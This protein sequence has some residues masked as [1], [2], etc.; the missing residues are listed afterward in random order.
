MHSALKH[1]G[2]RLYELA[3]RGESVERPPRRILI[4]RIRRTRPI[5]VAA[6]LVEFEVHCSKGTYIRSLAADIARS[7]GT[8]GYV[9]GLRRLSVD[10]FAGLAMVSLP[11]LEIGRRCGS[12]ALDSLLLGA[13]AAFLDLARVD[14][15]GAGEAA[16][17]QGQT[18]R[19]LEPAPP[20]PLRAYA[21][22]R[23]LGL[24]EGQSDGRIHPTRLFVGVSPPAGPG[25]VGP[26]PSTG[27]A[28]G[29][30]VLG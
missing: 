28:G 20:G 4:E 1:A 21:G 10:P 25:P 9:T 22:G 3:R 11:D 13:D 7:L 2:E 30:E 24:V 29:S 8:L 23:F 14:L 15:D 19:A 18:V 27:A 6:D 5:G 16:L 12:A 17:L 26:E